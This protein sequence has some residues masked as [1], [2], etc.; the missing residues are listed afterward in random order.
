[1]E[2]PQ[3]FQ[4]MDLQEGIGRSILRE[5]LVLHQT[6][7]GAHHS[8]RRSSDTRAFAVCVPRP[9][10]NHAATIASKLSYERLG[11]HRL[12]PLFV[13][14]AEMVQPR[15]LRHCRRGGSTADLNDDQAR[16]FHR[17]DVSICLDEVG[18]ARCA[19]K[20]PWGEYGESMGEA[21]GSIQRRRKRR[22]YI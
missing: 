9:V 14:S 6:I 15:R 1:M 10:A 19:W 8:L 18:A 3:T 22:Q 21:R 5:D 16:A 2:T 4:E 20:K 12:A 7:G 13:I 17:A 11:F